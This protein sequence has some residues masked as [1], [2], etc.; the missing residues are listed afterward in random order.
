MPP[1]SFKKILWKIFLG[2]LSSYDVRRGAAGRGWKGEIIALLLEGKGERKEGRGERARKSEASPEKEPANSRDCSLWGVEN[3]TPVQVG[4]APLESLP[5]PESSV[6]LL[7][8]QLLGPGG[9]SYRKASW[10]N[11]SRVKTTHTISGAGM[12]KMHEVR[13]PQER[14]KSLTRRVWTFLA[15]GLWWLWW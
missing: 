2:W 9:F 4:S 13:A 12:Q 1:C 8:T 11:A 7:C 10:V 15:T 3:A 5:I 6:H 14:E